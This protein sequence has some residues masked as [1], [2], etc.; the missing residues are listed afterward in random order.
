MTDE[1]KQATEELEHWQ[2]VI[3]KNKDKIK[4]KQR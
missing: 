4:I 3:I 2:E 1:E